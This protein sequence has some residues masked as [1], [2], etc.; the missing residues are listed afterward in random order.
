MIGGLLKVLVAQTGRYV[1]FQATRAFRPRAASSVPP[2]QLPPVAE[3]IHLSSRSDLVGGIKLD[4]G[5][6]T[7]KRA[8]FLG[9]DRRPFPGVD[10]VTDLTQKH[11]L[12][13]APEL[14]SVKLVA[15]VTPDGRTRFML[16]DNCVAEVHCSHFLEQL[17]LPTG[18]EPVY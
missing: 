9:V 16:P 8:G 2:A 7:G 13:D 12:F 17:A 1:R 10:G 6:G 3:G 5:C 18:F 4:L 11:W 15:V 14:G